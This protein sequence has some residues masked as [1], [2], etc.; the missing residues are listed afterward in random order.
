MTTVTT[1]VSESIAER[2]SSAEMHSWFVDLLRRPHPLPP[3]RLRRAADIA[4]MGAL[5]A[6]NADIVN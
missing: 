1:R 3:S 2:L 5:A 4:A 6:T